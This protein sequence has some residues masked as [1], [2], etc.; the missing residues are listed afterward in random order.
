MRRL[1]SRREDWN[2][3]GQSGC[4]L[5]EPTPMSHRLLLTV[6]QLKVVVHMRSSTTMRSSCL[7]RSMPGQWRSIIEVENTEVKKRAK[8]IAFTKRTLE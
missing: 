7:T 2:H 3:W 6:R 4:Q 5:M 8:K 1:G